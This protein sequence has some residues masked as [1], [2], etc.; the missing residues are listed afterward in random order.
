MPAS[1]ASDDSFDHLVG[2]R[3]QRERARN[4]KRH[5]SREGEVVLFG[6]H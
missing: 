3:E 6:C 5:G 1:T 4:P 2:Y